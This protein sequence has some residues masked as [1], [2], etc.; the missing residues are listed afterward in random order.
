MR[1]EGIADVGP[2]A[3]FVIDDDLLTP[4]L[5]ELFGDDPGIG[6]GRSASCNRHD[7]VNGPIRPS[8]SLCRISYI[9][10]EH[11]CGRHCKELTT[12]KHGNTPGHFGLPGRWWREETVRS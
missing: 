5:R 10:G 3:S 7:H 8:V 12:P 9:R 2:G 1:D 4:D 11:R 6:I